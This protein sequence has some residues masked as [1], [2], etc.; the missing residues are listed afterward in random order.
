MKV[1]AFLLDVFSLGF[2]ELLCTCVLECLCVGFTYLVVSWLTAFP[3]ESKPT[4]EKPVHDPPALCA[5]HHPQRVQGIR[6]VL[7]TTRPSL[8]P[9]P[10]PPSSP[11]PI[12]HLLL[13]PPYITCHCFPATYFEMRHCF[14]VYECIPVFISCSWSRYPVHI[15]IKQ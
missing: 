10:P 2:I 13:V 4:D 3:G 7:S 9:P 14:H 15:H 12:H 11:L 8:P 6:C 1:N 5:L